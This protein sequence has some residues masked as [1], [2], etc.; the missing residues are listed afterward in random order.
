[1]E[2]EV[3]VV[4]PHAESDET[5]LRKSFNISKSQLFHVL[6]EDSIYFTIF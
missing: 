5:E 4:F 1:M 3:I 2:F 6:G